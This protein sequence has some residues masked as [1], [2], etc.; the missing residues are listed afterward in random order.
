MRSHL[1]C[2]ITRILFEDR[3]LGTRRI[4]FGQAAD[5]FEQGRATRVIKELARNPLVGAIEARQHRI[6]KAF[7]AG[8]QIMEGKARAIFHPRSS[9]SRS[10][11][12]AQRA[13]GGKKLR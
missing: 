13:D 10:P 12:K 5:F 3:D 11:A 8:C 7:F 2:D 9:A 1:S 6:P 4:I